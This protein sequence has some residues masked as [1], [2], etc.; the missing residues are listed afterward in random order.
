MNSF[1]T[2][3]ELFNTNNIS[4]R[5]LNKF[6]YLKDPLNLQFNQSNVRVWHSFIF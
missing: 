5:E 2:G 6:N 4:I 1:F 3:T